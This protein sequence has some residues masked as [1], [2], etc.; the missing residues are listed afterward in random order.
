M[1]YFIS[2]SHEQK[3]IKEQIKHEG[4]KLAVETILN[5]LLCKDDWPLQLYHALLSPS[6]NRPK[7]ARKLKGSKTEE[8]NCF[9]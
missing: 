8:G 6:I 4:N 1:V 2:F 7:L 5:Q 9:Y 3:T